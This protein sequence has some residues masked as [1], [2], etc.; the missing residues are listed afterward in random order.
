MLT[1]L[2]HQDESL[3]KILSSLKTKYLTYIDSWDISHC[4][5]YKHP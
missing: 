5:Y 4:K 3:F 2:A 1:K